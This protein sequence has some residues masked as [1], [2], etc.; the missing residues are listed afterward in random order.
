MT[1]QPTELL[2]QL[3]AIIADVETLR[4][5][6]EQW[7]TLRRILSEMGYGPRLE[8]ATVA[9]LLP[10]PQVIAGI[11]ADSQEA[12]ASAAPKSNRGRRIITDE[13][14]AII[15]RVH[16]AGLGIRDIMREYGYSKSTIE[17]AL[18]RNGDGA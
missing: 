2:T 9:S 16:S 5:D 12:P 11:V 15:C 1:T 7:R 14:R 17:R 6:A 4:A 18:S 10:H 13:D 3:S 8:P